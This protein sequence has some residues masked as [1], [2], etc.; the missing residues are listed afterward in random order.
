MFS[1]SWCLFLDLYSNLANRRWGKKSWRF[2]FLSH[3]LNFA[4][5]STHFPILCNVAN[6]RLP[7]ARLTHSISSPYVHIIVHDL[8]VG[9]WYLASQSFVI[10][11]S[12]CLLFT[13]KSAVL[14]LDTGIFCY[15]K[16]KFSCTA[17]TTRVNVN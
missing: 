15:K 1:L 4:I 16:K 6:S 8:G 5:V 3:R 11:T 10:K 17:I 9:F 7:F 2:D 13:A 12:C 14:A